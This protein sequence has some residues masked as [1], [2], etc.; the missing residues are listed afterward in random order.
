MA[1]LDAT[2]IYITDA[3]RVGLMLRDKRLT[4]RGNAAL[5][6][7]EIERVSSGEFKL[8]APEVDG[9][10]NYVQVGSKNAFYANA[11]KDKAQ[12]FAYK[13]TDVGYELMIEGERPGVLDDYYD[14]GVGK[15]KSGYS[16][17]PLLIHTSVGRI[18]TAAAFG[19]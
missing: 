14:V 12:V 19:Q 10:D 11:N 18:W 15:W 13:H 6:R 1:T 9:N 17:I 3:R 16:H 8:R 5:T 2:E 4:L 7:F